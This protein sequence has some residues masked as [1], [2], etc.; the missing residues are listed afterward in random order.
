MGRY[1]TG[2]HAANSSRYQYASI[3]AVMP[4]F[5]FLVSRLFE[6]VPGPAGF[7]R[8]AFAAVLAFAAASMC[9]QWSVEIGHFASWR[10]TETRQ[11][12]LVDPAPAPFAVPGYPGFPTQRAKD[13]IEKYHL[14]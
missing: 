14:H 9:R 13:L 2:L 8:L 4:A 5:G 12:L 7:R 10:G 11:L 1:H 3:L 6:R